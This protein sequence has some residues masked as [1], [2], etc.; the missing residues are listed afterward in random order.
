MKNARISGR[1]RRVP[2]SLPTEM[3][4]EVTRLFSS[5]LGYLV[6]VGLPRRQPDAP[7]L[8]RE[9]LWV[10]DQS[11]T[12]LRLLHTDEDLRGVRGFREARL[13]LDDTHAQLTWPNGDQFTLAANRKL[14]LPAKQ[15]QLIHNHLS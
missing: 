7:E 13:Q 6:E 1:V 4:Y 8:L 11:V 2:S 15:R 10:T 5:P 14:A 9:W 12:S 3:H